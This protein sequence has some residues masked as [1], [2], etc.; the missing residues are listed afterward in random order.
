MRMSVLEETLLQQIQAAGLPEPVREFRFAP[1]RLFRWDGCWPAL[2]L[3][4]EVQGGLHTSGRHVRAGGYSRDCEK[5]NLGVL[6]GWSI[7]LFT[8]DM[9]ESGEAVRMLER[10]LSARDNK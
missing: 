6:R 9:I 5:H 4:Y 7:L 10:V 3:A 1:P 8:R 2:R